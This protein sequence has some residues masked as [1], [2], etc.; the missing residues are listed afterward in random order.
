MIDHAPG[1]AEEA[2][3]QIP[4]NRVAFED[5]ALCVHLCG[6]LGTADQV[7]IV[8]PAGKLAQELVKARGADAFPD[9]VTAAAKRADARGVGKEGQGKKGA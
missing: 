8:V 6:T 5:D 7:S 4:V 1:P 2:S 9:Y 3:N